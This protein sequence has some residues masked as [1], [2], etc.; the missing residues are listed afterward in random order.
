MEIREMQQRMHLA[1]QLLDQLEQANKD[2][3][4]LSSEADEDSG[5]ALSEARREGDGKIRSKRELYKQRTDELRACL[6]TITQ[7]TNDWHAFTTDPQNQRRWS[8][9][10]KLAKLGKETNARLKT[11]QERIQ[12]I[13]LQ[14]RLLEEEIRRMGDTVQR[15]ALL[16]LK[17]ASS[18]TSL[19]A[20][21]ERRQGILDDLCLLL[22]TIPVTAT[23]RLDPKNPADIRTLLS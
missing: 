9:P 1:R 14:N 11:E 15:D 22:P 19:I 6:A 16:R 18:H 13:V 10:F 12:G 23:C 21:L 17:D 8:Y 20:L 2:R 7:L 3:E 5:A 4:R